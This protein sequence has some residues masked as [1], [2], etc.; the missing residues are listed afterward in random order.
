MRK[1]PVLWPFLAVLAGL[2]NGQQLSVLDYLGP[3]VQSRNIGI[4]LTRPMKNRAPKQKEKPAAA[5]PGGRKGGRPMLFYAIVCGASCK[6]KTRGTFFV[7]RRAAPG[8]K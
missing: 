4:W 7:S 6:I 1:K 2:L 8:L 3:Q 5:V